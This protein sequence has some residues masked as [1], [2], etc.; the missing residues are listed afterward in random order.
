MNILNGT[1]AFNAMSAGQ[2]IE[3][4]H[5]GSDLDFDE[6]R[7]FPATVF[8][9]QDYEFRIAVVYMTIGLM[10]VPEAIKEAPV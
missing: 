8:I 4:R 2:K 1:E 10:Q 3:A 7:N 9:D 6:I 5:T